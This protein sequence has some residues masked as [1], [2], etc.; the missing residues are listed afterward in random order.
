M[1]TVTGYTAARMKQIEDAAI[2]K[3]AVVLDNLFLEPHGFATDPV[4]YPKIDAGNV[5]GPKGD[6]GATGEVTEAELAAGLAA[7]RVPAGTILMWAGD[8]LPSGGYLWCKGGTA[9]RAAQAALFAA[10]GT[11]YGVG[12][13]TTTFGLPNFDNRFPVGVGTAPHA[14][15][16]D[17]GGSKDA[18]LA[19]HQHNNPNHQH[20]TPNHQHSI[21]VHGHDMNHAHP[22]GLVEGS[23]TDHGHGFTTNTDGAHDHF[24]DY[25]TGAG[26]RSHLIKEDGTGVHRILIDGLGTDT[27]LWGGQ[28]GSG[29]E[30]HAHGGSTNGSNNPNGVSHA[31]YVTPETFY[32]RVA[33]QQAFLTPLNEG[34]SGSMVLGGGTTTPLIGTPVTNANLPPYITVNFI[35][36]T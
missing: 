16:N 20:S 10:I 15:L 17:R 6:R 21:P 1:A 18:I 34:G 36:K 19:E 8:V 31:H 12:N 5:R 9:D 22:R 29:G 3:G 26:H 28:P 27:L 7:T 11:K 23:N 4:T 2:I 32:G 33:D 30:T 24:Y 25:Y 14:A 35:I 13:G